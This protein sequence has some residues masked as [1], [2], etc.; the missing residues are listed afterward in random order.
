MEGRHMAIEIKE[1]KK[2]KVD[3]LKNLEENFTETEKVILSRRSTRWYKKEQVPEF[4]VNRI[5]EAGRFAPSAGN[6]QPWKFIVVREPKIIDDLTKSVVMICKFF[7][8]ILEYRTPG[9]FW[10]FP[11]AKFYTHLMP[12]KLH[13]V[14]FSAIS[15]IADGKLKLYHDAQ[16]VILIFKDVRGVTNPDLDCGIAGQNMAIAAHS[17]GLATCWVSFASVA[18]DYLG[19][20]WN[21]FFGI[22]YPYKFITSLAIGWPMGKP[23]GFVERPAH[24]VGWFEN[25]IKTV[26]DPSKADSSVSLGE[27]YTIPN[28]ADPRQ[29]HW[30]ELFF[31]YDKCNGCTSCERICPAS[32]IEMKDKKPVMTAGGAC[33]ACGDC[34]A[35]CPQG[36]IRMKSSYVFSKHFKTIDHSD[37]KLPRMK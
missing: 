12:G 11:I 17:M 5:L 24:S 28:Y 8:A 7:K 29:T 14:P 32:A 35:I 23:D 20:K 21:K 13:P 16:T 6:C 2:D 15:L 27:K 22:K 4:M 25:G 34:M 30:G 9:N 1:V 19:F 31:D 10:K 26:K 3:L 33:M 18:F 37:L 36:A